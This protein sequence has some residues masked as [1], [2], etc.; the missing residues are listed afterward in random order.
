MYF[1]NKKLNKGFTLIEIIVAFTVFS[2]VTMICTELI[3]R[4]Q[5]ARMKS[6]EVQ[7]VVDSVRFS[8]ESMTKHMRTG[9]DFVL[10]SCPPTAGNSRQIN[11]KDQNGEL[12]GYAF[13]NNGIYRVKNQVDCTRT[14]L[15]DTANPDSVP[16]TPPE[17]VTI[18]FQITLDGGGSTPNNG[19]PKITMSLQASSANPATRGYTT[20]NLETTV[21]QRL[22][23]P[24]G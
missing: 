14:E 9:K 16:I 5:D 22:R 17:I 18:L 20:M 12:W 15:P 19:Q 1:V 23:D 2:A 11:F 13:Y 6:I 21:I 7:N 3:I 8:V 24:K 10:A 4:T